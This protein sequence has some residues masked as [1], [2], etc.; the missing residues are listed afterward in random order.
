MAGGIAME[1]TA[2]NGDIPWPKTTKP[3]GRVKF[4]NR[5]KG[6]QLG[7]VLKLPI[8][9]NP[10]AALPEVVD[11]CLQHLGCRTEYRKRTC[12][13]FRLKTNI[14]ATGLRDPHPCVFLAASL[15]GESEIAALLPRS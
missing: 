13:A 12:D 14:P 2:L 8:G 9:P 1:S 3:S 5:D 6:E 10:T 4:L 11:A 15:L 7:Y